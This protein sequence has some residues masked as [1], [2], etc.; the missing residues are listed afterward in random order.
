MQ[1][2]ARPLLV[3]GEEEI[4]LQHEV[5]S[6][7]TINN[8]NNNN[9]K[10]DCEDSHI[11]PRVVVVVRCKLPNGEFR[12]F[13]ASACIVTLP[14]GVLRAAV[15]ND[16]DDDDEQHHSK[17]DN[18]TTTLTFV[19]KLPTPIIRS[20]QSLGIAVRNKIELLFSNRWWPEHV[21]KFLLANVYLNQSPTYHP[22]TTFLVESA[23]TSE[24]PNSPNILVCYVAGE[25]AER[26]ERQTDNE[27]RDECMEVL[28]KANVAVEAARITTN[29]D[30]DDPI[31]VHITR[32]RSDPHSRGSWTFYGKGSSPADVKEFRTNV[33]CR[34]E[35]RLFFA[36]EHTCG[37]SST[38]VQ[39]DDMG[40]VHG[41]WVSGEL[42]A[43]AAVKS[44]LC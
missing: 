33:E 43:E 24:H 10:Q 21:G 30:I 12:E 1:Q 14:L 6:I 29:D 2:L 19:P 40:C 32:W 34:D 4:L 17:D 36:G 41:A 11:S 22:Y 9:K 26:V 3:R 18:D 20:I 42:A 37:G 39:G 44:I 5:V 28:R 7:E 38:L 25:F 13:R 23:S 8:K 15:A 16:T 31:A 27:I 35:R